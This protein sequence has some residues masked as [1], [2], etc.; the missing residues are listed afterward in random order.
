MYLLLHSQSAQPSRI[1][2][3]FLCTRQKVN[4]HNKI[5]S[6]GRNPSDKARKI[7]IFVFAAEHLLWQSE[8]SVPPNELG[9]DLS[10][11]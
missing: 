8:N 5:Y 2:N 10:V 9:E 4:L 3:S 7:V 6:V 1:L 11:R